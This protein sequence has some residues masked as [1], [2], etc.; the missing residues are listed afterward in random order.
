MS[1]MAILWNPDQKYID[2]NEHIT[3]LGVRCRIK[4]IH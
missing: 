3:G 1:N 4:A 2:E